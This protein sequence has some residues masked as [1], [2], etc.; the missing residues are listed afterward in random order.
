MSNNNTKIVPVDN[1]GE[2]NV[3]AI[4]TNTDK[5]IMDEIRNEID[6]A[7]TFSCVMALLGLLLFCTIFGVI[8]R[9]VEEPEEVKRAKKYEEHLISVTA[10]LDRITLDE[11]TFNFTATATTNSPPTLNNITDPTKLLLT[12]EE[13]KLIDKLISGETPREQPMNNLNWDFAGSIFFC[14]TLCTTIGYGKFTASTDE[15]KVLTII[16]CLFGISYFGYVLTLFSER[17]LTFITSLLYKIKGKRKKLSN[18][19]DEEDEEANDQITEVLF[20]IFIS[21]IF[22]LCFAIAAWGYANWNFGNAVYFAFVTFTTV[23]LGD[24]YPSFSPGV[25]WWYRSAGYSLFALFALVGLAL[26][27]AIIEAVG[28]LMISLRKIAHRKALQLKRKAKAGFKKRKFT[29]TDDTI[30]GVTTEGTR[31]GVLKIPN[32]LERKEKAE[33]IIKE[34]VSR[35]VLESVRK[36]TGA[37]DDIYKKTMVL[38]E[39]LVNSKPEDNLQNSP[40][41]LA[42]AEEIWNVVPGSKVFLQSLINGGNLQ[43]KKQ[44]CV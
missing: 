33:K 24:F 41:I 12:A 22:I 14:L 37:G 34:T 5:E 32:E 30:A 27:S 40:N 17:T 8:L 29:K 26:V 44:S 15:G 42:R 36:E 6:N 25:E 11:T 3:N 43:K 7:K 9:F 18:S 31:I 28:I 1:D 38:V 20:L 13:R 2:E 19:D 39:E 4:H 35:S 23:G 21:I 10:I 16:I